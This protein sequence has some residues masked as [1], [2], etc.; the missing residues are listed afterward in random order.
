MLCLAVVLGLQRVQ[1]QRR[2][3]PASPAA[4]GG[5]RVEQGLSHAGQGATDTAAAQGP[6]SAGQEQA[7]SRA[8]QDAGRTGHPSTLAHH[9]RILTYITSHLSS[10]HRAFLEGCWPGLLASLPLF[11]ASDF[12]MFVTSGQ[13][14]SGKRVDTGFITSLF[15]QAGKAITI[16]E[17]PNPGYQEG[18]VLALVEGYRHGWFKGYDWVVRLNPDVL[19]RDDTFLL[20]AMGDDTVHGIFVDCLDRPCPTGR[21]CEDSIIHTDFFAVRP[22][23]VSRDA[24]LRLDG[25]NAEAAITRAF[26]GIVLDEADAWLPGAGPHRGSCRVRGA[27]SPVIHDHA[28]IWSCMA[29]ASIAGEG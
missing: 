22:R 25:S 1:V 29:N 11:R 20:Q 2:G 18:A 15:S 10:Q 19:V 23:A 7:A 26:S 14:A 6:S 12:M 17:R 13:A 8:V 21:R 27:A 28:H 9:P 5:S 4:R 16:H 3:L 24:V